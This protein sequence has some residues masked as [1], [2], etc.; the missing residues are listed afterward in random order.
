MREKGIF[1]TWVNISFAYL[2]T[3]IELKLLL[4]ICRSSATFFA[5]SLMRTSMKS[6]SLSTRILVLRKTNFL[7]PLL[8]LSNCWSL[9]TQKCAKMLLMQHGK[10]NV[11][12]ENPACQSSLVLPM[13]ALLLIK[14][15][16][17]TIWI[18]WIPLY[19]SSWSWCAESRIHMQIGLHGA[20]SR[21]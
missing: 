7:M 8:N 15:F 9:R 21:S 16:C 14:W 19:N 13:N 1:Q 2:V 18:C 10:S 5:S 12:S 4:L 11:W 3:L 6:I 20:I 17:E